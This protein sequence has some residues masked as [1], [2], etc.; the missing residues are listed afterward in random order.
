M[1]SRSLVLSM[2]SR[3]LKGGKYKSPGKSVTQ[4]QLAKETGRRDL[5]GKQATVL[6]KDAIKD[7][8]LPRGQK[9]I[10]SSRSKKVMSPAAC[11][12]GKMY[13]FSYLPE[14][15]QRLPFY[16]EY[17]VVL[18]LEQEAGG[19]LALNF[20]Y[21]RHEARADF[22]DELLD[23]VDN[24]D[25][26]SDPKAEIDV[27]YK[28][29]KSAKFKKYFRPCIRSYRYRNFASGAYEI[30]PKDWKIMMFLPL[31]RFCKM[32]REEVWRWCEATN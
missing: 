22:F 25:Y 23:F 13:F 31:E 26:E 7:A 18:M 12:P 6:I 15:R 32:S 30:A 1:N 28:M 17:P 9:G 16:D 2:L 24:S 8:R 4:E 19:F 11:Q 21:L 10:L 20:H 5:A 14:N 29:L 3:E 27:T